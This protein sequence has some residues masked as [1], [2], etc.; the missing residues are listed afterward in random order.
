MRRGRVA[1]RAMVD[2][3]IIDSVPLFADV[4]TGKPPFTGLLDAFAKSSTCED[5]LVLR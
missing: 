3:S 1:E 5:D 4:K 2:V